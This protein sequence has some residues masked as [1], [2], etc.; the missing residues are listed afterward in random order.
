VKAALSYVFVTALAAACLVA[1]S[2]I[3][4]RAQA[5]VEYGATLGTAAKGAAT[6][7]RKVGSSTSKTVGTAAEHLVPDEP[8]S[9]GE[10]WVRVEPDETKKRGAR[11]SRDR[12][13]TR[14]G[15]SARSTR[16]SSGGGS[17]TQWPKSRFDEY[18]R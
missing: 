4:A 6:G 8:G 11:A 12:S 18:K 15:S 7:A 3:D 10:G 9:S 1:F 16:T 13:R 14:G 5:M 17:T 2:A